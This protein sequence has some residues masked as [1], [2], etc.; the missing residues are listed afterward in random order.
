MYTKTNRIGDSWDDMRRQLGTDNAEGSHRASGLPDGP[1]RLQS[2]TYHPNEEKDRFIMDTLSPSGSVYVS[3][4]AE[5]AAQH[6]SSG[7]HQH[8]FFELL[9]VLEGEVYQN[10]ENRRHLYPTGSLC[11]L[12]RNTR[13]TE[14]HGTDFRVAFLQLSPEFLQSVYN[15][16]T[17]QYFAPE[18]DCPATELSEFL[19][20]NLSGVGSKKEYIDFIPLQQSARQGDMR[21]IFNKLAAEI[22]DPHRG[23]SFSVRV[24]CYRLFTLLADKT[25]YHTTP[26][27]IG[28]ETESVLYALITQ[29]MRETHGRISRSILE[30]ELHYS[31]VYL[32]KI[33][34]KYTGLP[35][36]D[37]GMTFC[38]ARAAEELVSTDKTVAEIAAALD[39]TNMTHF[40]KCFQQLYGETPSKYR[41]ARKVNQK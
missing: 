27:S 12:N 22:T 8:D 19:E 5:E 38:M 40:Y 10:I 3:L 21:E 29:R 33:V 18:R 23:S 26:V 9:F 14:E 34:K 4:T 11:L 2:I 32:N 35:L 13:H 31:G 24:L 39:F 41:K 1:F 15:D 30:E 7:L 28:T 6:L 37:Y 25:V 20:Q 16:F 36:F 17:L